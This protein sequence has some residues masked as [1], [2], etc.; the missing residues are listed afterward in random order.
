MTAVVQPLIVLF[1]AKQ[2]NLLVVGVPVAPDTFK[3]SRA[4]VKGVVRIFF[5]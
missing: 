3:G 2:V 1:K 5:W 4:V